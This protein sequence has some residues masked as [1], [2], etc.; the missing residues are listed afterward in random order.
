MLIEGTE[1]EYSETDKIALEFYLGQASETIEQYAQRL[2]RDYPHNWKNGSAKIGD[3][4]SAGA[5]YLWEHKKR[6]RR[7]GI[8]RELLGKKVNDQEYCF[9]I[10]KKE[11]S[12]YKPALKAHPEEVSDAVMNEIKALAKYKTGDQSE[13]A[14]KKVAKED[15]DYQKLKQRMQDEDLVINK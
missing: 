9:N 5:F 14:E 1:L 8:A 3:A 12:E 15:A 2:W 7:A 6:C 11:D 13:A 10:V 4:N